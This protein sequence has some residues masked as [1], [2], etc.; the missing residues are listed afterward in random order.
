[1]HDQVMAPE[2]IP[3]CLHAGPSKCQ[4]EE[5]Q[6]SR[7][8]VWSGCAYVASSVIALVEFLTQSDTCSLQFGV[9]SFKLKVVPTNQTKE[10]GACE[11]LVE[12]SILKVLQFLKNAET[13]RFF[14]APK[15]N[16]ALEMSLRNQFCF[17]KACDF[18]E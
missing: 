9:T 1:M 10:G 2:M 3:Q 12:L 6:E 8:P 5:G 14:R 18:I 4:E 7:H 13:L 11:L 17:C 15:G 16:A